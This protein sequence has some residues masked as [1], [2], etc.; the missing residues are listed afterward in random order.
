[1]QCNCRL[2]PA[3]TASCA[4]IL[5]TLET[6]T[7]LSGPWL[8]LPLLPPPPSSRPCGCEMLVALLVFRSQRLSKVDL[9][10]FS[11]RASCLSCLLV[12]VIA[13]VVDVAVVPDPCPRIGGPVP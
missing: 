7:C 9:L 4:P 10:I 2:F 8:L 3:H 11:G 1:M 5:S 6:L 13:S 12:R